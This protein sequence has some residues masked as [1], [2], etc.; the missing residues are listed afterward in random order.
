MFDLK[1]NFVKLIIINLIIIIKT[2]EWW[3]RSKFLHI[4]VITFLTLI[5]LTLKF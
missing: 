2:L 1:D 5:F 3:Q 4:K